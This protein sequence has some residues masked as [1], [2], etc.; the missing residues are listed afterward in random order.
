M[1]RPDCILKYVRYDRGVHQYGGL[2]VY[3]SMYD[4]AEVCLSVEA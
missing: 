3:Q 1:W 2:I 4:M